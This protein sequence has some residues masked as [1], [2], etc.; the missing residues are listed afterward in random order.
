M[1]G[2]SEFELSP[3]NKRLKNSNNRNPNRGFSGFWRV[4]AAL[5]EP[6]H[7]RPEPL[8][9]KKQK[10]FPEAGRKIRFLRNSHK[11]SKVV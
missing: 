2:P 11:I 10:S 1:F 7:S 6:N 4:C 5:E 9:P 3:L 8:Q